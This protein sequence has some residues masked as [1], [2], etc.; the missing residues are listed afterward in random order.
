MFSQWSYKWPCTDDRLG[1]VGKLNDWLKEWFQRG[2]K[3]AL[4]L[5]ASRWYPHAPVHRAYR[6]V[7]KDVDYQYNF[8]AKYGIFAPYHYYQHRLNLTY[9][10]DQLARKRANYVPR[11]LP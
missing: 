11:D 10:R 2:N 5:R 6:L 3:R 7:Q 9:I 1:L 8:N 4:I